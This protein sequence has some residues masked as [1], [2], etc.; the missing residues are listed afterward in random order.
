MPRT[1]IHRLLGGTAALALSALT[2][3]A[4]GGGG[5]STAATPGPSAPNGGA[6]TLGV[7]SNPGLGK[8]L[9]DSRGLTLYL[10]KS[11]TGTKSTCTGACA[12]SCPPLR[13][14]GKPSAGAGLSSAK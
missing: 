4:C 11:D 13:A 7:A 2:I 3:A 14:S 8:I 1:R 12:A 9:V 10:F 5:N 6:A